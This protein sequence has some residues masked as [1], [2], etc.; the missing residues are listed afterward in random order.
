VFVVVHRSRLVGAIGVAGFL[1]ALSA[2]TASPALGQPGL[3]KWKFTVSGTGRA[4]YVGTYTR[5]TEV[6]PYPKSTI[7]GCS[8]MYTETI[9]WTVI[10]V[11]AVVEALGRSG[12][13]LTFNPPAGALSVNVDMTGT[14]PHDTGDLATGCGKSTS[15]AVGEW[16]LSLKSPSQVSAEVIEYTGGHVCQYQGFGGF[17]D[18]EVPFY[19]SGPASAGSRLLS[20]CTSTECNFPSLITIA[21]ATPRTFCQKGP[22]QSSTYCQPPEEPDHWKDVSDYWHL[23]IRPEPLAGAQTLACSEGFAVCIEAPSKQQARADAAWDQEKFEE[24]KYAR[25][26]VFDCKIHSHETIGACLAQDALMVM[27]SALEASNDAIVADPPAAHFTQV[28]QPA[29]QTLVVTG[30]SA[31]NELLANLD[32]IMALAPV[33][34]TDID[35]ASA[36]AKAGDTTAAL[37][38]KRAFDSTAN[39]LAV[40]LYREPGLARDAA[41]V[42]RDDAAQAGKSSQKGF[43][44]LVATLDS[45]ADAQ[46][47][48]NEATLLR[49]LATENAASSAAVGPAPTPGKSGA[50]FDL[51]GNVTA[52]DL[53]AGTFSLTTLQGQK[54][55]SIHTNAKTAFEINYSL[56]TLSDLKVGMT[57]A[58]GGKVVGGVYTATAVGN[59]A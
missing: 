14:C 21:S 32:T 4:E 51:I 18:H 23:L 36:A 15:L 11:G 2:V 9:T 52:V 22:W 19:A 35:R 27:Y 49:T 1:V 40:A 53:K 39:Q 58:V 44:E 17:P 16:A 28:A 12:P 8:E 30:S 38:Q 34:A 31:L 6:I 46:D 48:L 26:D 20:Y 57:V 7:P 24:A 13:A 45:S 50:V 59:T 56:G 43:L 55:Y 29:G 5:P 37:A 47:L 33:L 41:G 54:T 42:F 3:N 25:E 10:N